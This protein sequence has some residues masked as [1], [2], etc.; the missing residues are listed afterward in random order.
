M[1]KAPTGDYIEEKLF[2][3]NKN[4]NSNMKT[5][6]RTGNRQRYKVQVRRK[7]EERARRHE[8]QKI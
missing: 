3:E 1:T 7:V 8:M 4:K 2:G 6:K 5:G